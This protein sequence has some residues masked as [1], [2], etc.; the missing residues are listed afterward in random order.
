ML[1]RERVFAAISGEETDRAPADFGAKPEVVERLL[2]HL[3]LPDREALLQHL[4]VDMRG[5]WFGYG[6][7]NSEPDE[8]GYIHN[9]WGAR[10]KPG[11]EGSSDKW[12]TP[13]NERTTVAEV[14]AFRWPDPE[15]LDY[16]GI[17]E[18]CAPH[19]DT[20]ATYGSP[21]C[22]FF[23]DIGWM[24]GQENFFIWLV[25]RPELIDAILDGIVTYQVE[26]TRRFLVACDGLLDIAY[27][28]NDFGS[29]RGLVLS[30][31]MWRRFLR[32]PLRR[33]Y[34]LSHEFGCRVMQ[35]SC[36][37]IRE[38]IPDLIEDGV[39]I[40]DPIQVRA[41]GMELPGLVRDFGDRLTFHGGV[42]TQGVLPFGTPEEVR[43]QVRSYRELTRAGGHYIL[44]GSQ[45]LIEDIP[46]ENILAMY[47]TDLRE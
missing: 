30:P 8:E 35:H 15:A 45:E 26:V 9:L 41:E 16:S 24:I 23:H 5:V 13:F 32:G 20:Y 42:D 1:P 44:T 46:T 43:A 4:Q 11:E 17:R 19:V 10:F 2:A 36:G 39:D 31:Q 29:Q 7:P 12:L 22:P 47:E 27:F 14:E 37:G 33:F 38:I 21:W 40:L 34:D 25:T 18:Q 28:G 3:G 6:Q